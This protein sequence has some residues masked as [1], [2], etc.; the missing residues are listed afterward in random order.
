MIDNREALLFKQVPEGYVYQAP[1]PWL[2]GRRRFFLVNEAQKAEL[3]AA[4]TARSQ[5][6][7][8][9]TFVVVFVALLAGSVAAV[10]YLAGD[11][12]HPIGITSATVVLTLLSLYAAAII[13]AQPAARRVRP[14]LERLTPTDQRITL[15]DRRAVAATQ[16]WLPGQLTL[17]ASHVIL[18]AMFFVQA[19]QR[20]GGDPAKIL[21]NVSTVTS[22]FAACCFA[23]S[24]TVMLIS[25]LRALKRGQLASV[26]A[27]QRVKKMLLPASVLVIAIGAL[28]VVIYAGQLDAKTAAATAQRRERSAEISKR[29]SIMTE[30]VNKST[31]ART[32]LKAR[33]AANT[34]RMTM[35]I[36]RLNHP[37]VKC[38]TPASS[39]C[40]E[41]AR[42]EKQAVEAD[43]AATS[44]EAG[45][46]SKE[47]AAIEKEAADIKAGLAAIR[48]E[49]DANR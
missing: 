22:T 9:M 18:S 25:T 29:V 27:D 31:A 38:E 41:R 1:N 26:P 6:A 14:L 17:C 48:V 46:L 32:S 34:A 13:I 2:F 8:V 35:L 42:Q 33:V 15:A 19:A 5:F 12:D 47:N 11:G 39:E 21:Q 44:Q 43:I 4:V 37:V 10:V 40:A 23:F 20:T 24:A 45:A 36:D 49:L 3:L 28:G 16:I 7:L 30:R